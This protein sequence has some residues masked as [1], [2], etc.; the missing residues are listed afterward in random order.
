MP[1]NHL[2]MSQNLF[3]TFIYLDVG[4]AFAT[5][6]LWEKINEEPKSLLWGVAAMLNTECN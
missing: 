6:I 5:K 4:L 1:L 2:F 3:C